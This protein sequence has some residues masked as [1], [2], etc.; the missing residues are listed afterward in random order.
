MAAGDARQ[1]AV[2]LGYD[3]GGTAP[4]RVLA[5]GR[6]ELAR[7]I[8]EAAAAHDVPV[9]HDA[10]LARALVEVEVGAMVPRELWQAVAAVLAWLARA[11]A[12]VRRRGTTSG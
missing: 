5:A 2:A 9:R 6:G 8:V 10:A 3:W 11:D 1:V 4:P 12:Q 7:R